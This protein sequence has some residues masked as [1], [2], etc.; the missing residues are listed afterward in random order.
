MLYYL[1][2][3]LGLIATSS[4]A[5]LDTRKID[6]NIEQLK[7]HDWFKKIYAQEKYRRLF[8]V[9]RHVRRYLQS[10]L[11]VKKMF[12][13]QRAQKKLLVLLNKQL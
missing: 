10:N 1:L 4:T 6:Q 9:N 12:Y 11:R 13:N 8:Y 2:D 7:K 5:G 3:L